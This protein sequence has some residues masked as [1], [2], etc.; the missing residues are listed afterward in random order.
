MAFEVGYS[1]NGSLSLQL[2]PHIMV[3]RGLCGSGTFQ[4]VVDPFD[5]SEFRVQAL[6]Y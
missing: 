2:K 3:C 1:G 4:L 6:G 5:D